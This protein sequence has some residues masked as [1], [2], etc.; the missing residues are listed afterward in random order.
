MSRLKIKP[1]DDFQCTKCGKWITKM[2]LVTMPGIK[3]K[4]TKEEELMDVAVRT[5]TVLTQSEKRSYFR[6]QVKKRKFRACPKCIKDAH[7]ALAKEQRTK[8]LPL[9][10]LEGQLC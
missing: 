7:K 10:K 6:K 2:L 5:S 1:K 9:P 3:R 8:P 4:L